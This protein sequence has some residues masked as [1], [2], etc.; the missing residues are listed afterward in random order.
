VD[1][2]QLHAQAADYISKQRHTDAFAI[3]ERLSEKGYADCQVYAGW[4]LFEGIGVPR[5]RPRALQHLLRAAQQGIPKGMF[6]VGRALTA[7]GKHDEA[8]FWYQNAAV[9]GYNPAIYR[10]GLSYLDGLG[11]TANRSLG[12]SYL[13]R[14]A[15]AG[16]ILAKREIALRF[17]SGELGIRMIPKGA[18]LYVR[19]LFETIRTASRKGLSEEFIG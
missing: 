11:T 8:F 1:D 2:E 13:Q 5:D 17:L 7:E 12:I 6:Y 10:L 19:A 14:A 4:M 15:Q 3:Y 9:N 16:N 18:W